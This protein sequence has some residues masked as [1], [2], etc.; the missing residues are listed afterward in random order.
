MIGSHTKQL[1]IKFFE[2]DGY[3][4]DYAI[5][6][7]DSSKIEEEGNIITITYDNGIVDVFE[8]KH[9]E[10]IHINDWDTMSDE[11]KQEI[12][13]KQRNNEKI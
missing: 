1:L 7:L 4:Y 5:K 8:K 6:M 3:E 12:R 13:E 2:D 11:E 9:D 10:V